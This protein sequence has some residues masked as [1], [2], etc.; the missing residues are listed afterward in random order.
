MLNNN[1]NRDKERR[2]KTITTTE[3]NSTK[4]KQQHR[5]K[6]SC[7]KIGWKERDRHILFLLNHNKQENGFVLNMVVTFMV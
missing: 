1:L 7:L 2:K 6:E 5:E 3:F 4:Q